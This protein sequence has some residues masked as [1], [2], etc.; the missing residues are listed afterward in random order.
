MNQDKNSK[1][2]QSVT[3]GDELT[4]K[5]EAFH[6]LSPNF[7]TL[8]FHSHDFY[9]IYLYIQ[10][11]TLYYVEDTVYDLIPGD[12]LIIP[13]GYMH[14]PVI[15]NPD[16]EYERM[17][18]W[19]EEST[20]REIQSDEYPLFELLTSFTGGRNFCVHFEPSEFQTVLEYFFRIMDTRKETESSYTLIGKAYLTLLMVELCRTATSAEETAPLPSQGLI[21][22]IIG[23]LNE[24]LTENITLDSICGQFFVSKYH[25][26]REFK[27]YTNKSLYAYIISKR[28]ILAKKL[29]REGATPSKACFLCGF[30]DY[31]NFY[32][33]FFAETQMT[34]KQFRASNSC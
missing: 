33:S 29:M 27:K 2:I 25:L 14:R 4:R 12:I 21:P 26:S 34:P 1:F 3:P 23:F 22:D 5:F 13:P 11:S 15:I 10:G 16:A 18:L 6:Y 24:H 7:H 8:G 32:K 30:H 28:I 31:S 19:V 20:L 9:E 17:Y